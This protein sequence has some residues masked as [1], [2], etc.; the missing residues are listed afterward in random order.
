[1]TLTRTKTSI[2]NLALDALRDIPLTDIDADDTPE[3]RWLLRNYDEVLE[4][5]LREH[6]WKFAIQNRRLW[7]FSF[8]LR[9]RS[10]TRHGTLSGAWGMVRLIESWTGDLVTIRRSSDSASDHFGFLLDE[11]EIELTDESGAILL[12]ETDI[13]TFLAGNTGYLSQLFDQ[14]GNGRHLAQATT[15]KQPVYSAAADVETSWAAAL[16]D[17]DDDLLATSSN[18]SNLISTS[19]GMLV[20]AGRIDEL[21]LDS[22]TAKSNHFLIGDQGQKIGLYARAGG[23]LYGWN[24]DGSGDTVTDHVPLLSP[25]VATIRHEGGTLYVSVNGRDEVSGTSGA[26]S[27]L[28]SVLQIGDI[29]GSNALDF[30][31]FAALAY[32]TPPAE[33]E[34][35]R[36]VERLMRWVRAGGAGHTAWR[37]RY[38]APDDC[39]R[40]LPLRDYGMFEGDLVPH[41]IEDMDILT[42]RGEYVD[43]R[44]IRRVTDPTRFDPSFVHAFAGRLAMKMAHGLTGKQSMVQ[45]AAAFYAEAISS[46]RKANALE[47]TPERPFASNVINARYMRGS[48]PYRVWPRVHL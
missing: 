5:E 33:E 38:T 46:A 20:I 11:D 43:A 28:A 29:G 4:A 14:S 13:A 48:A 35:K 45:T 9:G 18:L 15:T 24:D 30:H 41:E 1:M 40:M 44:Y 8:T 16:F 27:S 25:F 23:N 19:T 32:S 34:R 2:C 3:S 37:Y 26:T 31:F 7:P 12:D 39:L 10:G 42:N 17:G 6:V 36:I 22:A 47:G 21:A